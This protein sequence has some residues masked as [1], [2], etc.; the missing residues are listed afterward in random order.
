MKIWPFSK[1]DF[2]EDKKM[3]LSCS[4]VYPKDPGTTCTKMVYKGEC[5]VCGG[6]YTANEVR[7]RRVCDTCGLQIA[8]RKK[9]EVCGGAIFVRVN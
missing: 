7:E 1:L 9:M 4:G 3:C 5:L 6:D 2:I 8:K